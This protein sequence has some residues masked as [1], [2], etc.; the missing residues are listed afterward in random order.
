MTKVKWPGIVELI[1]H[2]YSK[3]WAVG[4]FNMSNLETL[5]AIVEAANDVKSP[6]MVGVS[7]TTIQHVGLTYLAALIQAARQISKVPLYFHLDHGRDFSTVEACINIGFDSVMI[8]VSRYPLERNI[9]MVRQVAELA[10]SQGVGVEGQVGETWDEKKGQVIQN[11]TNP[12]EAQCFVEATGIDYLAISFGNTPGRLKGESKVDLSVISN[13]AHIVRVPLVLHGGTSIARDMIRKAIRYGA[14]KI[15]IDAAIRRAVTRA[16]TDLCQ[17]Q[18]PPVDPRIYFEK[19]REVAKA[20]VIEKMQ[21]FGS[22]K[23]ADEITQC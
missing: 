10:H 17:Q 21:L 20:V 14:A 4:Q 22:T 9:A 15:N 13:I 19:V 5:K 18:S 3:H 11:L 1:G 23:R 6:V 8:D 16:I 7:M 12:T 2:A